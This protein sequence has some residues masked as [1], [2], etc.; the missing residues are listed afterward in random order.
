MLARIMRHEARVLAADRSLWALAGLLAAVVAYGALNGA[1][2]AETR[3]AAL[4]AAAAEEAAR[5]DELR[6]RLG[7]PGDAIG[8]GALEVGRS[9]GARYAAM[10]PGLLAALVVGQSDLL[11][12][13]VKVTTDGRQSLDGADEI[14]NPTHLLTGRFDLGFVIVVLYP[15]AILALS[16]DLLSAEK[17]RGTLALVLSQPVSLRQVVL[18]KVLLRGLLVVGL[19]VAISMV[20][21]AV[22]GGASGPGVLARAGL[23]MAVVAAYGAFW[24]ALAVAVNAMGRGSSA[25]ALILA[26]IWLALVAVVPALVNVAVKAVHPVPSRAELVQA[27]REASDEAQAEGSRLKARYFEDHPE[28]AGGDVDADEYAVQALAVQ[29]AVEASVR[30]IQGRFEAQLARQQAMVDRLR[31]LSP[32]I[33]TVEA[34]QDVAGTGAAR[35]RHFAGQVE[36]FH[37]SYRA[38]FRPRILR[39][40]PIGPKDLDAIPAFTFREE[41]LPGVAGRVALGLAGLVLPAVLVGAVG[42]KALGRYPIV[43]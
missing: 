5:F 1:S 41:P 27:L 32:A 24:F 38:F 29:E 22:G 18:G 14:E 37:E 31:F 2:W 7:S 43:G 6:R 12:S 40:E 23:W 11:P 21:L 26:G 4:E 30:D 20:G 35:A 3:R 17:E 13:Y 33:V 25:N 36:A 16:F 15:L 28:L 34:L 9:S 39:A 42:R 19:A 8:V 10:P